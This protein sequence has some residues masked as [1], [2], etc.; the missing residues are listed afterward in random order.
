MHRG[1]APRVLESLEAHMHK[2]RWLFLLASA[3][4]SD[5]RGLSTLDYK[6]RG[7]EVIGAALCFLSR[8]AQARQP[9]SRKAGG[10]ASNSDYGE[11]AR[12]CQ[13]D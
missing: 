1:G 7:G 4:A 12:A 2:E 9:C 8:I 11:S 13:R 3:V 10:T 5:N 6:E